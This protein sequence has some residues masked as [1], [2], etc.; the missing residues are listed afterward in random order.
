MYIDF[1]LAFKD[2]EEANAILYNTTPAVVDEDGVIIV[3]AYVTPNYQNISVL[4]TVYEPAPIP[5][6]EDYKPIPYPAPNWGVNV[7]LVEGEDAEALEPY[8]VEPEPFPQ[9]VWA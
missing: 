9:R 4:G 2:E 3:E 6:P 8:A 7:R 1:Y 5:T